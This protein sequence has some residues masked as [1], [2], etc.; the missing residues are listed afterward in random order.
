MKISQVYLDGKKVSMS[1]LWRVKKVISIRQ[2]IKAVYGSYT[3]A[4]DRQ[5]AYDI[6]NY[7]SRVNIFMNR[8]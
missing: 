8:K 5:H 3:P 1:E 2:K 6:G 7:D 4:E